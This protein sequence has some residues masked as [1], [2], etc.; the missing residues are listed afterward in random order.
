VTDQDTVARYRSKI[1]VV[2]GSPCAWCSSAVSGRGHG[3][4]WVGTIDGRDVVMIAHRFGWAV[5]YGVDALDQVPAGR[6]RL[7]RS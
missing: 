6:E 5:R 4:F 2:A 3:R 1:R 7:R